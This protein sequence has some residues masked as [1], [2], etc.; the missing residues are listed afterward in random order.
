MY[1]LSTHNRHSFN[2]TRSLDSKGIKRNTSKENS[3]RQQTPVVRTP[4]RRAER[5]RSQSGPKPLSPVNLQSDPFQ[6][7]T[8]H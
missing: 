6:S 1:S 5:I 2:T 3:P 8:Y 7:A 4:T